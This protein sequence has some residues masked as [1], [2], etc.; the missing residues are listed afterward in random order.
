MKKAYFRKLGQV[1]QKQ[2]NDIF[3]GLHGHGFI[4]LRTFRKSGKAVVTLVRFALE[5]GKVYVSTGTKSGK[6]LRI[7]RNPKVQVAPCT[8][9]GK[10][11]GPTV[12]VMGRILPPRRKGTSRECP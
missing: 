6:A 5:S 3:A 10:V 12:E 4:S 8:I 1:F 9:S 7:R 11:V 2:E